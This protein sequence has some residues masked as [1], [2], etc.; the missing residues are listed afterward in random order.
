MSFK[1]QCQAIE[2]ILSDVDGVMTDGGVIFDNQGIEAKRFHIHDGMGIHLWRKSG[3]PFGIVTGR[4]SQIVRI[5]ATELEIDILRQ[6]VTNKLAAVEEIQ[7]EL[8][9]TAEQI[10]YLGDDLP[11]VPVMKHVGLGVAVADACADVRRAADHVTQARGGQGA[12]REII[13]AILQA[14]GR[15]EDLIQPYL[16]GR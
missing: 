13:E 9:L 12:V 8:D 10:C 14:Q 5:R 2:L 4:S 3:K 15:W 11:D 7:R 6:G 16:S 1:H